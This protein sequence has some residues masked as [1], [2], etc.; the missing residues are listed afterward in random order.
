MPG[1]HGCELFRLRRRRIAA[2]HHVHI[3]PQQQEIVSVDIARRGVGNVECLERR[4]DC[5]KCLLQGLRIGTRAAEPQQRVAVAATDA[6]LHRGAVVEPHM[7]QTRAR[8]GGR[9]NRPASTTIAI[10]GLAREGALLEIEAV[11]VLPPAGRA[12]A[13]GKA[14]AAAK[15]S[16]TKRK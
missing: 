5:G 13:T 16:R 8:P 10:S 6:I 1:G 4:A 7:R 12:K 2:P 14:R 15:T 3:G 9:V 11:A